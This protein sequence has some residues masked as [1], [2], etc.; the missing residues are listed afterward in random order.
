MIR[1]SIFVS[2]VALLGYSP[3]A[4]SQD[5]PYQL[6]WSMTTPTDIAETHQYQV[7]KSVTSIKGN[8]F[9]LVREIP[10]P[11]K[12][13]LVKAS[14]ILLQKIDETGKILWSHRYAEKKVAQ[15]DFI[16]ILTD[17][18][19]NV[20]LAANFKGTFHYDPTNQAS[21]FDAG[22]NNNNSILLHFDAAGKVQH[23]SVQKVPVYGQKVKGIRLVGNYIYTLKERAIIAADKAVYQYQVEKTAIKE[24]V[25]PQLLDIPLSFD[26]SDVVLDFEIGK[27]GEI[28]VLIDKRKMTE[29]RFEIQKMN[30]EGGKIWSYSIPKGAPTHLAID[31]NNDVYWAGTYSLDKGNIDNKNIDTE[32]NGKSDLVL[33]KLNSFGQLV[34]ANVIGDQLEE[35]L[36]GMQVSPLG[37]IYLA[38]E[39]Y[40][41]NVPQ[42]AVAPYTKLIGR[43]LQHI[44]MK[45]REQWTHTLEATNL[46]EESSFELFPSNNPNTLTFATSISKDSDIDPSD[47]VVLSDKEAVGFVWVQW[48]KAAPVKSKG[49]SSADLRILGNR[50]VDLQKD[51]KTMTP[52]NDVLQMDD[53]SRKKIPTQERRKK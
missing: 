42:E 36:T 10:L 14:D 29:P 41:S 30:I 52:V 26:R 33:G 44:D 27:V 25:E 2:L 34:F 5:N 24:G 46:S 49:I 6:Q 18:A 1:S 16:E 8:T 48:K 23:A 22:T 38:Y 19:E 51:K 45:G 39:V 50:K 31:G 4:H 9:A 12:D 37:D 13:G 40:Q 35:R 53:K 17:N 20:Y 21:S 32:L 47:N 7:L 43:N 15:V 28:Y 11:T 3:I